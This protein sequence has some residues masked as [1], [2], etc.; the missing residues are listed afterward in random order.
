MKNMTKNI[1]VASIA[2]MAMNTQAAVLTFDSGVA[3]GSTSCNN[4]SY[5]SQSYGDVAGSVDVSYVNVNNP[6]LSLRWWDSNYNNLRGVLWADGSDASSWARIEIRSLTGGNVTLNGFD[7]GAYFNTSRDTHIRITN[8]GGDSLFYSYS[9]PVGST[10]NNS[11]TA[12]VLGNV[13]AQGGLWIDW[14]NSA[15]N[16]GIDN[17]DY[18]VTATPPVPEPETYAMLMAGLGLVG[19]MARRRK[20]KA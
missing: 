17:I 2:A 10:V 7:F 15:Y 11:A 20:Q 12:F 9:G 8:I 13:T 19:F 3:C 6:N 14:K 16:V 5:V 18:S 1:V 4:N